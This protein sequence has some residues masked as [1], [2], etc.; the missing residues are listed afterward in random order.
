MNKVPKI[1]I[2]IPTLNAASVLE[3][4][5]RS[6]ANQDYPKEKIEVIVAD[7]SKRVRQVGHLILEN[8][9]PKR[10][11][12]L[13]VFLLISKWGRMISISKNNL[14]F[15]TGILG[16][17]LKMVNGKNCLNFRVWFWECFF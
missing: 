2:L 8:I 4:C 12:T 17:L 1:S 5:F 11:I 13:K 15:G 3:K 10:N 6:I 9:Y 7:G 14:V 16:F